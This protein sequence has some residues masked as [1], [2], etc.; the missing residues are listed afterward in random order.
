[1]FTIKEERG[2]SI[3][4]LI[5]EELEK[6]AFELHFN[7][8]ILET[9]VKQSSAIA[10]YQKIGFE[11]VDNYGEYEGNSNSICMAKEIRIKW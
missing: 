1:M 10:M 11:I 5:V 6:W 9:G 2:Q 8:M 4:K 3:G 7:R